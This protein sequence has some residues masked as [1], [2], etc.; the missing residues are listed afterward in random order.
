MYLSIKKI[1][2]INNKI[3]NKDKMTNIFKKKES[4]FTV[5]NN[6]NSKIE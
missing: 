3:Y 1:N 2:N 5:N 6:M 4:G